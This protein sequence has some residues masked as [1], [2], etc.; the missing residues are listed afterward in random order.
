MS[1][2]MGRPIADLDDFLE[3]APPPNL[4]P[5]PETAPLHSV[6][7][8]R[9]PWL[10]AAAATLLAIGGVAY[11]WLGAARSANPAATP[12]AFDIPVPADGAAGFAELFIVAYLSGDSADITTFAP[13]AAVEAMTPGAHVVRHAAAVAV[14]TVAAGYWRVLIAADVLDLTAEG[15]VASGLQHFQVGVVDDGGRLVA[16]GLPSRVA[17]PPLRAAPPRAL[18]TAGSDAPAESAAIAG[19]FFEAL[20]TGDR[21]LA[22]YTSDESSIAAVRPAPYVAVAV[23]SL[24]QFDGGEL[25][26]TLEA[27]NE[28]GAIHTLEYTLRLDDATG[29]VAEVMAGPPPITTEGS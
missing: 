2:A 7:R 12:E 26:A 24:R 8:S 29:L 17:S 6:E 27:Q 21:Q 20:L 14:D 15:Y 25:L 1:A 5:A 16:A 19:D 23:T 18:Q 9:L 3:E 4:Q 22:R 28:H 10:L 13:T 11:W